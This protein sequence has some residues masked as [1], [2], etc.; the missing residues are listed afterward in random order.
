MRKPGFIARCQGLNLAL[1]FGSYNFD[2]VV[3]VVDAKLA[4]QIVWLCFYH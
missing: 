1:H 4:S 3:T 2:P